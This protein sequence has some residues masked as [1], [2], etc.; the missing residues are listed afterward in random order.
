MANLICPFCNSQFT[1]FGKSYGFFGRRFYVFCRCGA[2][3]P[4]AKTKELAS[5]KWNSRCRIWV[6]GDDLISDYSAEELQEN[7]VNSLTRDGFKPAF[8]HKDVKDDI[9]KKG[10]SN[11]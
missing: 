7:I 6:Y 5:L 11:D 4:L 9:G 1:G 8:A 10:V 3:G 2:Q